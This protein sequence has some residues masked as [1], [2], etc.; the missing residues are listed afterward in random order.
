MVSYLYDYLI[1]ES[2]LHELHI[3]GQGP[4]DRYFILKSLEMWFYFEMPR[5]LQDRE[6]SVMDVG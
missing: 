1:S 3:G 6:A 2:E 4:E 5:S